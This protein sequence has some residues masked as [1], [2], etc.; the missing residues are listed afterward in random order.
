MSA[1]EF[2]EWSVMFSAEELH[3]S[4]ERF[5]HAQV[6]AAL[7]NGPLTR[8]S[9]KLWDAAEFMRD[10]WKAPEAKKRMTPAQVAR[11]VASINSVRRGNRGN[12]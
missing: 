7:H 11:Q 5:R 10:G 2:A 8:K 4:A 3:P 6:M 12:N 9:K 1:E